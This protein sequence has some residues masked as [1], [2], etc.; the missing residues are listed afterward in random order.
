MAISTVGAM[1]GRVKWKKTKRRS[2]LKFNDP[3]PHDA[4]HPKW[5]SRIT[6]KYTNDLQGPAGDNLRNLSNTECLFE[7]S[8]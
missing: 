7:R 8:Q 5:L 1:V 6:F 3:L 2:C 4:S